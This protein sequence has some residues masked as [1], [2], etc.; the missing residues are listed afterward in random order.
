MD[1]TKSCWNCLNSLL[2]LGTTWKLQYG[3]FVRLAS[4]TTLPW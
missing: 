2:L 4:T 1:D 3:V